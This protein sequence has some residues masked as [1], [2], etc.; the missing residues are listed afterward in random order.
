MPPAAATSADGAAS[1]SA[2]G[3]VTISTDTATLLD[4][5]KEAGGDVIGLDWRVDIAAEWKRLGEV[6]VQGNFDPVL[7]FANP[8]VIRAEARKILEA[9]GSKPGFIFNLGHGILPE[10]PVE[11]VMA[12]VDFVHSWPTR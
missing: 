4:L 6:A 12:L 10:T 3:Q 7:L 1:D 11:N 8:E 5:V 2:Q 9:V